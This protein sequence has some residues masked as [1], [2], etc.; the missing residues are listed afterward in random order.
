M[1]IDLKVFYLKSAMLSTTG[2]QP[3]LN[4]LYRDRRSVVFFYK[5]H[6][7][8]WKKLKNKF[9]FGTNE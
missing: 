4:N 9:T 8:F 6:K 1:K 3:R 7:Y 5:V 2:L